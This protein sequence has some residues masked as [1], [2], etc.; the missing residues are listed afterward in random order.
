MSLL[1]E[2]S[3]T[4]CQNRCFFGSDVSHLGVYDAVSLIS[5]ICASA[6]IKTL[7]KI[8]ISSGDY[9]YFITSTP[10]QAPYLILWSCQK[11]PGD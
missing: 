10:R 6:S 2:W 7:E 3:G 1:M 5:N 4:V 8:G 11:K 9:C